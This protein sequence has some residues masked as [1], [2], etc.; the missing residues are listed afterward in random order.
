MNLWLPKLEYAENML[1]NEDRTDLRTDVKLISQLVKKQPELFDQTVHYVSYLLFFIAFYLQLECFDSELISVI[2]DKTLREIQARFVTD[3]SHIFL[4]MEIELYR[5]KMARSSGLPDAKNSKQIPVIL[6]YRSFQIYRQKDQ[7][8]T[9][10]RPVT[11]QTT[12]Q[13]HLFLT[14]K[15]V[16]TTQSA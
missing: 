5:V 8:R 7:S 4:S 15:M 2:L 16:I 6:I 13:W 10:M 1:L 14:W 9:L 11:S 3:K 12:A